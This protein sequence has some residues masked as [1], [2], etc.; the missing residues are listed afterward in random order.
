M[1][2]FFV[3]FS[4]LTS[5]WHKLNY[6]FSHIMELAEQSS[7]LKWVISCIMAA[8]FIMHLQSGTIIFQDV[9]QTI[10]NTRS[11]SKSAHQPSPIHILGTKVSRRRLR[12]PLRWSHYEVLPSAA[13]LKNNGSTVILKLYSP[14]DSRPEICGGELGGSYHFVEASFKW[15]IHR[16]EHSIDSHTFSLEMQA[17]HRCPQKRGLFEYLTISFLFMVTPFKNGPL[18]NIT[19][20]LRWITRPESTIEL[21]PFDLHLLM[22][23]FSGGYYTYQGTYDNGDILLPTIWVIGSHIF[24]V[25]SHQ[26]AQFRSL[27]RNDCSRITTNAR[28]MQPQGNR[29]VQYHP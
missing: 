20:N 21:P 23:P 26:L 28:K 25:S 14:P 15:G 29:C 22:Q 6:C 24:G 17:L 12:L 3:V 2:N 8:A 10:A 7:L 1:P 4:I 5:F 13:L 16:S 11:R 19:D 27:C 9:M 18:Q